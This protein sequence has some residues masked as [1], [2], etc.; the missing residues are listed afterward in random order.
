MITKTKR[1]KTGYPE[2]ANVLF[3][4]PQIARRVGE[5]ARRI[6]ADYTGRKPV[7]IGMLKGS[8]MFIADLLRQIKIPVELDF[9]CVSSYVGET[10]SG[11]IKMNFD[12]KAEICDRDVILIDDIVDTGFSLA[13]VRKHIM[14]RQPKSLE[15]C[16]LLDKAAR[17]KVFVPVRYTGFTVQDAFLVGYG[18][19]YN[20]RYRELPVIGTLKKE[21]L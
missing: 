14:A 18:L 2:L 16:V 13:W 21:N 11:M 6:N 3:S 5:L 8:F 17:R 12:I 19:D 10:S 15:I 7:I 20:E 4:K 9:L 1:V